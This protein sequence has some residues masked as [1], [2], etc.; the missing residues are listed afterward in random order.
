MDASQGNDASEVIRDTE[1]RR[2][3]ALVNADVD[4][5][6]DL[7][8]DE[9]QLINPFGRSLSKGDYLNGI[10]T[11]QINYLVWEPISII[12]VQRFGWLAVIR[13]RSTLE[14][15]VG[16]QRHPPREH[17]HTDSYELR[18]GRWQ[19]VWSQATLIQ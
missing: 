19:V 10:E 17:W 14:I 11:G 18:N 9:F 2:L 3:R 6:S 13:Y 1:R 7:H 4:S 5:A 12:E 8:A 15:I 16:G